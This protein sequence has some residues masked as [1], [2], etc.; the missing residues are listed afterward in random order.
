VSDETRDG[1]DAREAA[2]RPH[3]AEWFGQVRDFWWNADFLELMARRWQL[4]KV[5]SA[6]DVGAGVGHWGRLLA[7]HLAPGARVTG[8]DR[9]PRWIDEAHRRAEAAGLGDRLRYRLGD[10]ERIPFH[11]GVFDLV[12]CQTLLIHV[13]DPLAVVR[14]MMRVLRPGGLLAVAEPNNLAN[15]LVLGSTAFRADAE[16]ILDVV[17]LHLVCMRGKEALGEGHNAVGELLPGVFAE[18]GL[19]EVTAYVSDKAG[20]LVPP[21]RSD[22]QRARRGAALDWAAREVFAWDRAETR[23]FF[24]AGGGTEGELDRLWGAAGAIARGTAAA[25]EAGVEHQAGG[26]MQYLI[27]GRKPA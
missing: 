7:P 9:E 12:T 2:E 21:Y 20:A 22:E 10:A 4:A 19:T 24:L 16:R 5:S 8:I 23:R 15:L 17:R 11:D 27:S 13:R 14:E 3:S 1:R 18:A 26:S 25:L 6:L